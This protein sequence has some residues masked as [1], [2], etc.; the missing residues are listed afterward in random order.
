MAEKP[1]KEED[2]TPI[3]GVKTHHDVLR[4]LATYGPARSDAEREELLGVINE[5]DPDYEAPAEEED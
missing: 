2:K 5:D 3:T 1:A 4:H